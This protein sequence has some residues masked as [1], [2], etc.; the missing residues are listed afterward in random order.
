M[1]Q[2]SLEISILLQKFQT[3][4]D[5]LN[6]TRGNKYETMENKSLTQSRWMVM[7]DMRDTCLANQ[8][9]CNYKL[10]QITFSS[11]RKFKAYRLFNIVSLTTVF[12]V[13]LLLSVDDR[14]WHNL[15]ENNPIIKL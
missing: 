6:T 1:Q 5:S 14:A 2:T 8:F 12:D 11:R 15:R 3:L 4:S 10:S 13:L 7:R 9:R